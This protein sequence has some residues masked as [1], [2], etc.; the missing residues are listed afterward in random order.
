MI[1]NRQKLLAVRCIQLQFFLQRR[2][3]FF[4]RHEPFELCSYDALLIDDKDPRLRVK[5]PLFDRRKHF[6]LGK[7]FPYLLMRERHS[8]PLGCKQLPQD[9]DYRTAHAAC[10]ELRLA[11]RNG[12]RYAD[13][14]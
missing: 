10:A 6:L 12:I 4:Y 2:F 13:P 7:V 3:Q 1:S 14:V 8:S 5:P 11:L 9:I